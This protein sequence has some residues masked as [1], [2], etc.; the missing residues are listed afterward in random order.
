MRLPQIQ[1]TTVDAKV[2][3]SIRP[4]QQHLEQPQAK[5]SIS[6]PRPS[7]QIRT[8]D[9]RLTIDSSQVQR[10]MGHY[11]PSEMMIRY[12]Q[13]GKQGAL[14]G[15]SRRVQ[16]GRQMMLGA[17]KGGHGKTIQQIAKQNTGPKRPGPYNIK[18]I[19]SIGAV[20][21]NYQPGA[22]DVNIER[23]EPKIDVQIQKPIHHYTPG[24]VSSTL[25]QRPEVHIDVMS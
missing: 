18:F 6:Q 5:L 2:D 11:P 21:I 8:T 17:G 20:K 13:E 19:P 15:I 22:V 16:E 3:L 23:H 25:V 7:L 10:E 14:K 1:I 24:S 12:A 9:S 4:P